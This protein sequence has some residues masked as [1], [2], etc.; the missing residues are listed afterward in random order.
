VRAVISDTGPIHYL[1]LIGHSDILADLFE[2]VIIPSMVFEE[3]G[4]AYQQRDPLQSFF[5]P[6]A[7]F[8]KLCFTL[9][10]TIRPINS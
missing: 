7:A 5:F 8:A 2:K 6:F 1:I 10:L 3:L 4:R 9:N